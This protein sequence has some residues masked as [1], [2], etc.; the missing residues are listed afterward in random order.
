LTKCKFDF[1]CREDVRRLQTPPRSDPRR[2]ERRF[3]NGERENPK[4]GHRTN[5]PAHIVSM[6]SGFIVGKRY[7][8]IVCN[9]E[10]FPD[11]T[12]HGGA[13]TTRPRTIRSANQRF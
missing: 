1:A 4:A 11:T 10:Q 9:R 12:A 3:P 13:A 8:E 7:Y 2:K 5:Q 6:L